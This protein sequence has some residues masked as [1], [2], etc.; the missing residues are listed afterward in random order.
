M[1]PVRGVTNVSGRSRNSAVVVHQTDEDPREATP[2]AGTFLMLLCLPM[3]SKRD[4]DDG[5]R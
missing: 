5:S 2:A 4:E 3:Q 1:R